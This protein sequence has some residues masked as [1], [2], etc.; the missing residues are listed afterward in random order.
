MNKS[1]PIIIDISKDLTFQYLN[2]LR[3]HEEEVGLIL[4]GHLLIEYVLNEIIRKRFKC[5]GP[6]LKDQ[7]AYTFSVK[8]QMVYSAG[9]LPIF[10]FKNIKRINRI[11]NQLAHHLTFRLDAGEFKFTRTDG[12]EI[13]VKCKGRPPKYPAR[14]YCK[15]LCF[16]TL[17]QLRNH[18]ALEVGELPLHP[19][20]QILERK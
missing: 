4:K 10:L 3:Y 15:M 8:L 9:Y 7:R 11:R 5:P 12:N 16:G 2:T 13:L 20:V 19:D 17:S 6:I 1:Q 14:H 18:F